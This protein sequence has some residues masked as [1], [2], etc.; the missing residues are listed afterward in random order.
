MNNT[1]YCSSTNA[2]R[3]GIDFQTGHLLIVSVYSS[4]FLLGLTANLLTIWPIIQQV[5]QQKNVLG[6][7]LFTL[8]M[9]DL[10]Y[11]L[12]LPL[13]IKYILG[14]SV[15]TLG[16]ASC[17]LVAFVFY[18][19]MYISVFLLCCISL[20]RYLAVVY[21]IRSLAFRSRRSAAGICIIVTF[22]VFAFH[23]SVTLRSVEQDDSS[24][25]DTYPLQSS[26][27]RF[28]YFR[29]VTGF[30]LP[31]L[32]LT[33]SYLNIFKGVKQSTSLSDQKKAKVKH[34]SIAVIVIFLLC[35][36]PY[37]LLLLLRT[38]V[39]SSHMDPDASCVFEQKV[40]FCFSMA[41][42]MSSLNSALDPIL[43]ILVSDSVKADLK[44]AFRCRAS[45]PQNVGPPPPTG[46]AGI[47]RSTDNPLQ[48]K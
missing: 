36:A 25:Y 11:T 32:V 4:V 21:P 5:R 15:W 28:N 45:T 42:A 35:F 14:R 22:L 9:S 39:F 2:P 19:N 47:K 6:I 8:V 38:A 46:E 24:C 48:P 17:T 29:F 27:A 13:W 18:S 33:A 44:R 34:L 40:H 23:L 7:Y 43:Y 16:N 10:F 12:T 31:L 37:H 3:C 20:D 1:S 30:L 41:L 26:V